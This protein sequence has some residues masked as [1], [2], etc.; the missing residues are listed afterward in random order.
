MVHCW[1]R[2][3]IS[4]IID[5]LESKVE[6]SD[7]NNGDG[8]EDKDADLSRGHESPAAPEQVVAGKFLVF[9]ERHDQ[10]VFGLDHGTAVT[11]GSSWGGG[12]GC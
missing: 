12:S 2:Y 5:S 1:W 6:N 8:A 4:I 3:C 11:L 7:D 10:L 9:S